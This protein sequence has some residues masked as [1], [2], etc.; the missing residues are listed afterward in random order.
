MRLIK[1]NNVLSGIKSVIP[2]IHN[3]PELFQEVCRIV[4]Q[5]GEFCSASIHT[6]NITLPIHYVAAYSAI[7]PDRL[8]EMQRLTIAMGALPDSPLSIAAC[9]MRIVICNQLAS[10]PALEIFNDAIAKL[11]HSS[12]AFLPL[13]RD[14]KAHAVLS[15]YATRKDFFDIEEIHFL[16][17]LASDLS[18]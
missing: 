5:Q 16:N 4:V 14:N 12:A 11:G 7:S 6:V 10:E 2:R 17:Q 18:F 8:S 13:V 1:I 15:L 3:R 9:D